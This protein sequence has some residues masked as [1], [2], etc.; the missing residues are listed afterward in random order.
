MIEFVRQI[1]EFHGLFKIECDNFELF[2][3]AKETNQTAYWLIGNQAPELSAEVQSKWLNICI[4][5]TQDPA[6]SKNISILYLWEVSEFSNDVFDKVRLAEEDRYFFKKHVLPYTRSEFEELNKVIIK[7]GVSNVF[8]K[9]ATDRHIFSQYK[10]NVPLGGWQSL[11]YR[12]AIKLPLISIGNLSTASLSDLE[13]KIENRIA[14]SPD[15]HLLKALN[16]IVDTETELNDLSNEEIFSS[17]V[18]KLDQEG[19]EL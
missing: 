17:L 19:Y 14:N 15:W 2:G 6:L 18:H 9:L 1:L 10:S 12:L 13:E 16:K 3:K 11:I 5:S 4:S 7:E 8:S